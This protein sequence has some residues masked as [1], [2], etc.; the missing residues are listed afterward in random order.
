MLKEWARDTC[1]RTLSSLAIK[2]VFNQGRREPFDLVIV[3]L[4]NSDCMLAVA[5]KLKAPVI[6]LSRYC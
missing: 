5:E 4:F 1:E 2:N 3:E 6:G